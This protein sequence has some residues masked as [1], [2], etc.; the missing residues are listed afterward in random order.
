M[1]LL[2]NLA[3]ITIDDPVPRGARPPPPQPGDATISSVGPPPKR[4]RRPESASNNFPKTN[5]TAP[6]GGAAPHRRLAQVEQIDR[7]YCRRSASRARVRAEIKVNGASFLLIAQSESP[8]RAKPGVLCACWRIWRALPSMT[9][10]L[11]ALGRRRPNQAMPPSAASVHRPSAI[12][13]PKSASNNFPKTNT[14]APAGGAAP[15]R[16]LAQVEQIDRCY[17]RRSA[18]RARVRAEIKVNG[19]SFLLI[20]Q[21]ESPARAKPGVLCAC[22][23]IWRALPSM[24]RY[25]AALGRRRPNQAMPPSAAS[26][27]R[28]SAIVAPN[29]PAIISLKR[30][31][32]RRPAAQ[33]H[34]AGSRRSS[35]SIAVIAA[36]LP[37]ARA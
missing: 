34:T 19:A 7:C 12:V 20:A 27:H 10:Y 17:C 25:L 22:W 9:R 36:A 4:H 30:T 23:R 2:E 3:G 18:S 5:T 11:A 24:T 14:T 31:R 29:P 15:H 28:P 16:R 1:C 8:A 21:S 33:H 26:V 37:R 6:A 13:A 35:R 32:R